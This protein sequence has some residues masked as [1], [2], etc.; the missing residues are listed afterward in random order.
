MENILVK[1]FQEMGLQLLPSTGIPSINY[2]APFLTVSA[3][4]KMNLAN[5]RLPE[6]TR[7]IIFCSKVLTW[8]A[9]NHSLLS[10]LE[11]SLILCLGNNSD[12]IWSLHV[13]CHFLFL[14]FSL[15]VQ[16]EVYLFEWLWGVKNIYKIISHPSTL[17]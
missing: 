13:T 9:V 10:F 12:S 8:N 11:C 16:R 15:W 7:I 2:T 1:Y 6:D 14:F 17:F 4:S 5:V 3:T